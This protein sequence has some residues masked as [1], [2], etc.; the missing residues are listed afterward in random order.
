MKNLNQGLLKSATLLSVCWGLSFGLTAYGLVGTHAKNAAEQ[1]GA[2][3]V[4]EIK[5][6]EGNSS[7]TKEAKHDLDMLVQE[8]VKLGRVD[9]I[10]IAAWADR[11]YP[12]SRTETVAKSDLALAK[13]RSE[14]LRLYLHNG[15]KE[16]F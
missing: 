10:E 14:A 15:L 12:G 3:E 5:F 1:L 13:K 2:S 16:S 9:S 8:A 4:I 6:T 11:E 7:L